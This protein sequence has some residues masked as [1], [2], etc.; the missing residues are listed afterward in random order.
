M[1]SVGIITIHRVYNYGS[2]L[3]AYALSRVVR[4]MGYD[5]EVIDYIYPNEFQKTCIVDNV[6]EAKRKSTGSKQKI[7]KYCYALE[8]LKQ[9]KKMRCAIKDLIPLSTQKYYS[10]VDLTNISEKYDIYLTGSDQV[11]NPIYTKG[12]P[13]FFLKFVSE[14]KKKISYSASFGIS[15]IDNKYRKLYSDLLLR[16]NHISVR[17]K[18]G[19][20]LVSELTDNKVCAKTVLDPTLLLDRAQWNSL[21]SPKRLIKKKYILCYFLNYTF[22]AFPYADQLIE[23]FQKCTGYEIVRLGRPPV[24]FFNHRQKFYVEAGPLEMLQLV[25]DAEL[26]LTT[27][28]HGTAFAVNFGVPVYSVVESVSANDSRQISLLDQLGLKKRVISIGDP[29]PA[30]DNLQY[31]ISYS[32]YSLCELRKQSLEFLKQSLND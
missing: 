15:E 29:F 23:Y 16:Y 17:E 18:S 26:V 10:I 27:S 5:V 21:L 32:Q 9:H 7:L 20:R 11:W 4:E 14:S 24:K 28:F 8:L 12:D 30:M 31:D 2:I 19:E 22:N 3:Q 6:D 13:A 25:R 1:Q